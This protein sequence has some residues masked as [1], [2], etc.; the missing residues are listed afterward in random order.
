MSARRAEFVFANLIVN[1]QKEADFFP[2]EMS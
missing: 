2:Y 1:Y